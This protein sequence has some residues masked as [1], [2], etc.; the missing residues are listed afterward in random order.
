MCQPQ[1]WA[2]QVP[3]YVHC[4]CILYVWA[5]YRYMHMPGYQFMYVHEFWEPVLYRHKADRM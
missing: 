4:T 2:R 3:V 1:T 5:L